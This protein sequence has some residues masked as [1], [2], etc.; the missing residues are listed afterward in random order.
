MFENEVRLKQEEL[1]S[2][3][4]WTVRNVVIYAGHLVS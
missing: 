4:C 2:L 3:E 1:A